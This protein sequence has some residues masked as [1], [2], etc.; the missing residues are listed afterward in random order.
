MSPSPCK[1][2]HKPTTATTITSHPK[3]NTTTNK[4]TDTSTTLSANFAHPAKSPSPPPPSQPQQQPP[5]TTIDYD[6]ETYLQLVADGHKTPNQVYREERARH[7]TSRSLDPA[8]ISDPRG[9]P[10][11]IDFEWAEESQ[12][13]SQG[14][15]RC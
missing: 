1:P 11:S 6:H 2:Q 10:S 9:E 5:P 3:H 7:R 15:T 4:D 14:Q 8:I 12:R 13:R